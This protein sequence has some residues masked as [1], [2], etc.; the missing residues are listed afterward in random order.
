VNKI[1][2][3]I[4]FLLL[5]CAACFGQSSYKG[6][7]PGKSTRAE[8]ERVLGRPTS[9]VSESLFEYAQ[10]GSQIYVQY[11]KT[12]PTA[13]R[14]QAIYSPAIERSKVL[15]AERLPKV[16]DTRRTNKHGALEEYFGYPNYVVLTYDESSQTQVGQ[17]GY[18]S[19]ELFE[20]VTPELAKSTLTSG[21]TSLPR[22]IRECETYQGA[23]CGTWTL[24]GNQFQAAW[25]NGAKA[26]LT[27]ER[28][29]SGAVVI[30][31]RDTNSDFTARYT[32]Q[33]S[34]NRIER[35]TVTWTSQG[36]S[37]SGTWTANW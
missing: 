37:W 13:I 8:V 10:G 34:G 22:V 3:S 28:F 18:Y 20:S 27:I 23:I 16:A 12:L 30:I 29:D 35:G 19:R 26:M 11:S 2:F 17:V 9:Q 21:A 4:L 25:E 14:I 33:L 24:Q 5:T 31:R 6:L 36:Q 15:A 7:T 32:G 1:T